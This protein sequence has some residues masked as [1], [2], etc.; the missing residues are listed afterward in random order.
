MD[1]FPY[2]ATS[3]STREEWIPEPIAATPPWLRG[4][5]DEASAVTLSGVLPDEALG[6]TTQGDTRAFGPMTALYGALQPT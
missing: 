6:S 3:T 2:S 1:S 5:D 4:Q